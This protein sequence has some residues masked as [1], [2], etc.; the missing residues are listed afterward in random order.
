V[1]EIIVEHKDSGNHE[2]VRC[3]LDSCELGKSKDS[4]LR[5]RG[6]KVA[7]RHV[8][9]EKNIAGVF[10]KDISRGFGVSVNG[11]VCAGYGPMEEADVIEFGSYKVNVRLADAEEVSE[12][13]N[14]DGSDTAD[15]CE[16]EAKSPPF[17]VAVLIWNGQS[18]FI[19]S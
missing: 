18:L 2:K 10:I 14:L 19:K 5:L 4:I 1:F 7:P 12:A 16:I 11:N 15:A 8:L 3:G 9:L 13:N 17:L 6:W